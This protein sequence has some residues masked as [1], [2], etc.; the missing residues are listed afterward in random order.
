MNTTDALEQLNTLISIIEAENSKTETRALHGRALAA[1]KRIA[2]SESHYF[3]K[4]QRY[5]N[6]ANIKLAHQIITPMIYA[7]RDDLEAGWLSTVKEIIHAEVFSDYLEM[8]EHL[9]SSGFKDASAVI[10]G[11]TLEAHIKKLCQKNQIETIN[12]KGKNIQASKLNE[13]LAKKGI[14]NLLE[15]QGVTA[16][17]AVRNSA[18]HGRYDD[19][20]QDQIVAL[21]E[22]VR[23]FILRNPA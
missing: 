16:A 23:S 4:A 20:G 2:G 14:Y 8:A 5:Y 6:S 18:A 7:L 22:N 11:S 1:I 10:I 19:Y 12:P 21:K 3:L 15:Q 17:L 9:L 13:D